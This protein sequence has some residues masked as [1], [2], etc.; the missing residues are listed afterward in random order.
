MPQGLISGVDFLL[1]NHNQEIFLYFQHKTIFFLHLQ[2]ALD[3]T[4]N[5]FPFY[6]TMKWREKDS[7]KEHQKMICIMNEEQAELDWITFVLRWF[8]KN[9]FLV[10]YRYHLRLFEVPSR[11]G[12]V[13]KLFLRRMELLCSL[14]KVCGETA[15]Q[16]EK[17]TQTHWHSTEV[18]S[19][20]NSLRGNFKKSTKID[21]LRRAADSS[22]VDESSLAGSNLGGSMDSSL[23]ADGLASR[24]PFG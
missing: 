6:D 18:S 17:S 2:V 8:M 20:E 15:P 14:I 4:N 1:L 22:G 10:C 13:I 5:F 24:S 7:R 16:K 9:S 21:H 19:D 3:F 23:A 12:P 11:N